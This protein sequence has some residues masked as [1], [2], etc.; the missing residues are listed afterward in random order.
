[1][2]ESL[3]CW[4]VMSMLETALRTGAHGICLGGGGKEA[5]CRKGH[6]K[7]VLER[8][9]AAYWVAGRA[10]IRSG[11]RSRVTTKLFSYAGAL[12]TAMH[13]TGLVKGTASGP[14]IVED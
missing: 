4:A 13:L 14:S 3:A 1:M 12:L 10:E 5:F 2:C 8:Q 9:K 6:L 11:A 7:P